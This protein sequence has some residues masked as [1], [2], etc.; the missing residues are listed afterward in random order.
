MFRE[1]SFPSRGPPTPKHPLCSFR[2]FRPLPSVS[3]LTPPAPTLK[4]RPAGGLWL[5]GSISKDQGA[6]GRLS[7]TQPGPGEE[8]LGC[9]SAARE[10]AALGLR[11]V[12]SRKPVLPQETRGSQMALTPALSSAVFVA[13]PWGCGIRLGSSLVLTTQSCVTLGMLINL[14]EPR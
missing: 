11:R 7:L 10:E 2:P 12:I 6:P 3:H 5:L 8:L 1:C 13:L 14:P 9:R 4:C